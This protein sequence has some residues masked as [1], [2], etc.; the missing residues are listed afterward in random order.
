MRRILTAGLAV[1]A[2]VLFVFGLTAQVQA[3]V[4]TRLVYVSNTSN[5]PEAGKG[6]LVIDVEAKS[7][8]SAEEISAFQDAFQ[9]DAT[10]RSQNPTVTFSDELFPS[11]G[12]TTTEDYRSSDGRVRYIYTY[13]SGTVSSIGTEWTRVVRVTIEYTMTDASGSVSWYDGNPNFYVTNSANAVITGNEEPIPPELTD[14]SL[15]VELALFT[16]K[17]GEAGVV[18]R[19]VTETE[20]NN[21]GFNLYR[22]EK[23][24]GD[25]T[26]INASLIHGAGTAS[27]RHQYAYVDQSVLEGKTY[28]YKL[29]S[30]SYDGS[31]VEHGPISVTFGLTTQS[32][33]LPDHFEL[34]QNYPN[35]FNPTTELRYQV[36]EAT[37]VRIVVLDATGRLVKTLVSGKI[38]AGQHT[39]RWD[40]RDEN[41]RVMGSGV[42]FVKMVAGDYVQI[43]KMVLVR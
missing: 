27:T 18:I 12:Y 21:L 6:T 1:A 16:A 9:L 14:I 43:R 35:P 33:E 30:V 20:V 15:P 24:A 25:Y 32:V 23:E 39:A 5:Y 4:D 26:K 41:G 22:S 13:N 31:R 8:A 34:G 2:L 36:P 28:W 19:W 17:T 42:Y 40:G 3:A 29:E 38:T 7:N 11:S 37:D 10:F